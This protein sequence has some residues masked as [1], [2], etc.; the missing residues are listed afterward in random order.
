MILRNTKL[1]FESQ[2]EHC[3]VIRKVPLHSGGQK[4]YHCVIRKSFEMFWEETGQ[5]HENRS[6][7]SKLGC[8]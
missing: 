3:C 8:V 5:K 6:V 1:Y 7:F 2:K 4:E